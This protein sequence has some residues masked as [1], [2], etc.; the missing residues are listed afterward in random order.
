[1]NYFYSVTLVLAVSILHYTEAW[2]LDPSC[3]SDTNATNYQTTIENG[4]KQAFIYNEAALEALNALSNQ[5]NTDR[6]TNVAQRDLFK[7]LFSVAM[8]NGNIDP[9]YSK[10]KMLRSAFR[11]V[12]K[13][14]RRGDGFS[15]PLTG[16]ELLP[17]NDLIVYCD[18]SRFDEGASCS[19]KKDPKVA[20]DRDLQQDV[21]MGQ[22]YKSCKTGQKEA[23]ITFTHHEDQNK[24]AQIQMCS[25]Y[26]KKSHKHPL[27]FWKDISLQ[28][29]LAKPQTVMGG[30][31]NGANP[32]DIAAAGI[33]HTL[34][35]DMIHAIGQGKI[36]DVH[37]HETGAD[38]VDEGAPERQA[39][40]G[41]SHC[42]RFSPYGPS[43][44]SMDKARALENADN[45][46]YFGLGASLISP[47]GV[48]KPQRVNPD[49]SLQVIPKPKDKRGDPQM[50]A[51]AMAAVPRD[52]GG[53]VSGPSS[54]PSTHT[55]T[56]PASSDPVTSSPASS[57]HSSA[58]STSPH[59]SVTPSNA[60]NAVITPRYDFQDLYGDYNFF[61][62]AQSVL[63]VLEA[64]TVPPVTGI[65]PTPLATFT[66]PKFTTG[67]QKTS[68][69][70]NP[71]TSTG[72]PQ[73]S[74]HKTSTHTTSVH[75]T[76]T[77]ATHTSTATSAG[78]WCAPTG[79]ASVGIPLDYAQVNI[80]DFCAL[81][82]DSMF[83]AAR[84]NLPVPDSPIKNYE[85]EY[86]FP[87]MTLYLNISLASGQYDIQTDVCHSK[88]AEILNGCAP[89]KKQP[90]A[91]HLYKFGGTIPVPGPSGT[92]IF[93]ISVGHGGTGN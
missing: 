22:L 53:A 5:S 59:S 47:A 3:R 70:P 39:S 87:D 92:A 60:A 29:L 11:A 46:A 20:C 57:H 19:G 72:L 43:S 84:F 79:A 73:T 76:S 28:A 50:R 12:K 14:D 4:M 8:D 55:S 82:P 36:G 74:T 49:G 34:F 1:M 10:F 13:F 15:L 44:E 18:W 80:T 86:D 67:T 27:K 68:T 31:L 51:P 17:T 32:I 16:N 38:G 37:V 35:H 54:G 7:Y 78:L 89:F 75:K 58:A 62:T 63:S 81:R 6:A 33:G 2:I 64:N 40:Y 88:M 69:H 83:G 61:D 21:A 90:K 41:W 52:G 71:S 26:L 25:K 93:D 9:S 85:N 56:K 24:L 45:Y 91:Q 77:H 30:I 66:T 42:L 23:P 65:T 48:G